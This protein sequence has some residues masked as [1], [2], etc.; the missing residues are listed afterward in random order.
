MPPMD[1]TEFLFIMWLLLLT[2]IVAYLISIKLVV[3]TKLFAI[4]LFVPLIIYVT[5]AC[6]FL[7]PDI[8][9][10]L[11]RKY[12]SDFREIQDLIPQLFFTGALLI[13]YSIWA[14]RDINKDEKRKH[15]QE[16]LVQS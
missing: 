15:Q 3:D 5:L 9:E 1:F 8:T 2:P 13:I 12:V 14:L 7:A 16:R 11:L 6:I 4:K 10:P